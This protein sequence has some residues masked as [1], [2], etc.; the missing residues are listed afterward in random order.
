[1]RTS[2]VSMAGTVSLAL[3]GGLVGAVPVA[4][5]DLD[6]AT[7]TV[8]QD[9]DFGTSPIV[10]S[11]VASDPR[12]TGTLTHDEAGAIG[13]PEPEPENAAGLSWLD[14]TL[15]GPEG[16]WNVRVYLGWTDPMSLFTVVSG[17]GANEGWNYIA[18]SV[19]EIVL[20][21]MVDWTGMFYE[22]ELVPFGKGELSPF[23]SVEPSDE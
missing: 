15:D 20:D 11:W 2:R 21:G 14:G 9:C 4:A 10:C 6:G 23:G 18:W 22:G 13:D 17:N 1:M 3:L 8:T 12:L 19:D 5:Q 7:V 16:D